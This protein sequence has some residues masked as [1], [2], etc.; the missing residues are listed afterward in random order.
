VFNDGQKPEVW[1]DRK[2]R[3][4]AKGYNGNGGGTPLAMAATLWATPNVPNGGRGVREGAS[5]T[6]M[7]PDGTK[8]QIDLGNQATVWQTPQ[9]DSFRSRGGARK[10][11]QGL[12]QQ[13]RV[14]PTPAARDYR[15]PNAKPYSERGGQTKGEQ[16][17]NFI[18]HS[19]PTPTSTDCKASRR[20]G[21]MIEGNQG[22][23]LHDAMDQF[24]SS[25]P[26]PATE[27]DGSE[28]SSERRTLNPQFV[29]WLMNLPIGWTASE[30]SATAVYLFKE[31]MRSELLSLGQPDEAPAQLSL[32]I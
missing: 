29:E 32:L 14:W 24:H 19:W 27:K 17:P 28:S 18:A 11:E 31:R 12:D 6:G 15:S 9:T 2:Q 1:L 13:A 22:T 20:H 10:D 4:L 30:C 8:R 26:A 3:E 21:Y 5:P 23:T 16:L 25:H 7:M